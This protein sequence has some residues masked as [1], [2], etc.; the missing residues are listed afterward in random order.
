MPSAAEL[1]AQRRIEIKVGKFTFIGRRPTQ[2]DAIRLGLN[3]NST[4]L[5][6]A[7]NLVDGWK[8]VTEFDVFGTGDKEAP[9]PFDK[10]LW[11][12]WID[13]RGDFWVPIADAVCDAW[14]AHTEGVKEA[15]GE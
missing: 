12:E 7:R 11:L 14:V 3:R 2:G 4:V 10:D 8:D 1:R 15:A 9:L 5:D 13:D 6:F